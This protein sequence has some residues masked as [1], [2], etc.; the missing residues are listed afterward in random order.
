M[1]DIVDPNKTKPNQESRLSE[2]SGAKRK[3]IWREL[4]ETV[5]SNYKERTEKNLIESDGTLI[6]NNSK[7]DQ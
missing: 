4:I 7:G 3:Q 1:N 6:I 2:L 5:T